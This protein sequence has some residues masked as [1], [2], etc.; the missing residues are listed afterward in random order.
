[1]FAQPSAKTVENREVWARRDLPP[2]VV[3]YSSERVHLGNS[4]W[5]G[6][7]S[8][9]ASYEVCW[10]SIRLSHAPALDRVQ[11]DSEVEG[12]GDGLFIFNLVS[13]YNV[14]PDFRNQQRSGK[15]E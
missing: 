6:K 11:A 9:A 12:S 5:G 3:S 14:H 4:N 1:M 8:F 7:S 15:I 2:H 13:G 10:E